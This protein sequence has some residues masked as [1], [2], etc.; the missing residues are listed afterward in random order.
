MHRIL[1]QP[2]FLEWQANAR[3]ALRLGWPPESIDWQDRTAPQSGFDFAEEPLIETS[4][5]ATDIK[6]PRGFLEVAQ[7]VARHSA[8]DR[9]ALLYRAL[10]RITRGERELLD[11]PVDPDG[12]AIRSYEKQV[13][14]DAY[15]ITAFLRFR[16]IQVEGEPWLVAWYEPEHDSLE[17]VVDFFTARF[18]N[19][20]WSILTPRRCMH[21]DCEQLSWSEGTAKSAAPQADDTESLWVAYYS[22]IFNPARLNLRAMQ[23]QLLK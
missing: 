20:R 14:K 6:V 5:P 17:L 23:A 19:F 13:R 11:N 15:R 18:A 3:K 7:V 16:E 4:T 8:P 2:D 12:L 1:L 10:W 21:W 22:R 9:W